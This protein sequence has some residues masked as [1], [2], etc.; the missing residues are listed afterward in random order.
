LQ[1]VQF[2]FS[3]F[4]LH[5]SFKRVADERGVVLGDEVGYSIRFDEKFSPR[6]VAKYMTDG[7]LLR[8]AMLDPLLSKYSVLI[9]DEAHERTLNTEILFGLVKELVNGKR[10]HDLKLIIMSATLDVE[11]FA[12]YFKYAPIISILGCI[13]Y[14]TLCHIMSHLML[15][16][17]FLA[18]IFSAKVLFIA[19][20]QF[21][22]DV[23]Y[24]AEAQ[25]DYVDATVTAIVQIH[26]EHPLPQQQVK[27]KEDRKRKKCSHLFISFFLGSLWCL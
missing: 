27:K 15:L 12:K 4:I 17:P 16:A 9:L 7:M 1:L 8:E 5:P 3:T 21:A 18:P 13:R 25:D 11:M 22:V 23:F 10:K 2:H 6:T 20:R 14:V 19:G 26:L 24:T